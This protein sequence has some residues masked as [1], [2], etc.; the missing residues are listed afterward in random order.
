MT[1]EQ[2]LRMAEMR[3]LLALAFPDRL[4]PAAT[5]VTPPAPKR[6]WSDAI[7]L[8]ALI[9]SVCSVVWTG[10]VI[11][12]QQ[13]E[14]TRR[15]AALEQVDREREPLLRDINSKLS[16]VEALLEREGK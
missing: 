10:G 6:P 11:Y 3:E 8:A 1:A 14:H 7:S 12:G 9:L 5:I 13:Q 2:E 16:R 4:P 15:I